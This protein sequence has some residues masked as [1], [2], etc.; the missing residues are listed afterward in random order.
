MMEASELKTTASRLLF[1]ILD[2]PDFSTTPEEER[3]TK[4]DQVAEKLLRDLKREVV[5]SEDLVALERALAEARKRGAKE[6]ERTL[7]AKFSVL[8]RENQ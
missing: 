1:R 3:A 6:E 4:A 7:L 2:G 8:S 5:R